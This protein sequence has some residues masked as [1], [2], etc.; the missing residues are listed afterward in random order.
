M[1]VVKH[2]RC[3]IGS[4]YQHAADGVLNILHSGNPCIL[5]RIGADQGGGAQ[6][7]LILGGA[8]GPTSSAQVTHLKG[9]VHSTG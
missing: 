2:W 7:A 5:A 1:T 4:N 9:H 3:S 8:D 6:I